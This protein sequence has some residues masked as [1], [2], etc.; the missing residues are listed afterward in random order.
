MTFRSNINLNVK[1][2]NLSL[3]RKSKSH[4]FQQKAVKYQVEKQKHCKYLK[5]K[6]THSQRK[7]CKCWKFKRKHVH[8]SITSNA[9]IYLFLDKTLP[10]YRRI[11]GVNQNC[12]FI[13]I[14]L[15]N[16]RIFTFSRPFLVLHP[17]IE[18]TKLQHLGEE[19]LTYRLYHSI[20][21]FFVIKLSSFFSWE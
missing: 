13:F 12:F 1:T 18:T 2:E 8:K 17:Q 16:R 9:L 14:F 5:Q 21:S 11:F 15:L 3:N 7:H 19:S 6:R 20:K 4:N 10:R